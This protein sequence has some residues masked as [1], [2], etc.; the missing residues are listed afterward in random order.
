MTA[1]THDFTIE[2]GVTLSKSFI[3]KDSAGVAVNL[4]GYTARMQIRREVNATTTYLSATNT[5]GKLVIDAANGKIT[6]SLT[7]EETSAFTW[8]TGVYD[9][10]V[11]ASDGTVTRL[12][13]GTITISQEV[14]R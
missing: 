13:Q 1:A 10:E 6:L 7:D 12:V 8:P 5:N 3:W 4:T 14:T 11:E 9:L 2:Q